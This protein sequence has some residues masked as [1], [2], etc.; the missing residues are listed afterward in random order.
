LGH[1]FLTLLKHLQEIGK[2]NM[3]SEIWFI[4]FK[5]TLSPNNPLNN[6]GST[7]MVGTA[8]VEVESG[9]VVRATEVLKE[10]IIERGEQLLDLWKLERYYPESKDVLT[11]LQKAD[12]NYS[13]EDYRRQISMALDNAYN[14][15]RK[16]SFINCMSSD[17][18]E[19]EGEG[20]WNE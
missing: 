18:L 19:E 13:D 11:V 1:Q 10:K 3:A 20:N 2:S 7:Y 9:G 12:P 15:G 16:I 4:Q 17:F 5:Q 14:V 8:I 6:D